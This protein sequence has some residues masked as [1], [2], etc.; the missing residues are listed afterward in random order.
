MR[1]G[2]KL[3]VMVGVMVGAV[4][5]PAGPTV[6]TNLVSE[7]APTASRTRR[8][9]VAVPVCPAAGVI[10]A[11]AM[12]RRL[13]LANVI[14]LDMGGTTTKAS[15]V[16]EYEIRR[17]SEFEVGGPISRGS[18]LNKG[19]GYLLRTP[20]IDIAEVGAGGG[21]VEHGHPRDTFAIKLKVAAD[22]VQPIQR[23]HLAGHFGAKSSRFVCE[24]TRASLVA[25][26]SGAVNAL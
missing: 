22:R 12:A 14:S 18:R 25:G 3:G 13:C 11:A 5:V 2:R 21:S 9:M 7:V 16:E 1:G 10:G 4:F 19:G 24:P 8:V 26:C 17:S 23:E 20:A 15:V 6:R